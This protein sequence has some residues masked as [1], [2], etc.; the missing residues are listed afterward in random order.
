MISDFAARLAAAGLSPAEAARKQQL[1]AAAAEA[2]QARG[3]AT[4]RPPA[5]WFIP[6]RVELLGKHTD[7]AGGRSLLCTVERGFCFMARARVDDRIAISDLRS[8]Q[9][10]RFDLSRSLIAP[11]RSLSRDWTVYPRT[12]ARRL[13]QDFGI[14]RGVELAFAS[15]LPYASGLS[16]SSAFSIG[17]FFA[18]GAANRLPEHSL[19]RAHLVAPQ[20]LAEYLG[21]LENG[22]PFGPFEATE[23]VGTLGGC[24]DQAAILMASPG[25]VIQFRF[26]PVCLERRVPFP[27]RYALVI[28]SSGVVAEKTGAAMES[29][30]RAARATIAI[31]Q[32]WLGTGARDPNLGAALARSREVVPELRK[33]LAGEPALLARLEQFAAETEELIPAAGA[34]LSVG[35]LDAFGRLVDRSQAGAESGLGNQIPE[36]IHLQRA[37]RRLGAVAASAFGA[38]FGGSVWTMVEMERAEA[39]RLAWDA[40]YL[41]AFPERK[42]RAEFFLSRPGPAALRLA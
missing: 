38:G 12:V 41:K 8:G 34:A 35:G 33:L 39:F 9:S 25:E 31:H 40:N 23:G 27:E 1:F 3:G 42:H 4:A 30:N 20:A 2:L 29:Y 37:A 32:R 11:P 15:D 26:L 22:R 6:G 18:L 36:T 13:V 10:T 14:T 28:G 16:S 21:C 5:A 24:E 7:Y 17:V 19:Y